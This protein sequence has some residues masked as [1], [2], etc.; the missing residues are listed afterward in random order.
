MWSNYVTGNVDSWFDGGVPSMFSVT[1]TN[2]DNQTIPYNADGN[3]PDPYYDLS[4]SRNGVGTSSGS[5]V[6]PMVPATD[7]SGDSRSDPSDV[8]AFAHSPGSSNGPP[9]APNGLKIVARN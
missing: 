7:Y 5:P 1:G 3:R 4:A 6:A 9:A 2:Y 8:G